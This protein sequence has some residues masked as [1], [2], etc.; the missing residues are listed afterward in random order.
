MYKYVHKHPPKKTQ[1]NVKAGWER[2]MSQFMP[3]LAFAYKHITLPFSFCRRTAIIWRLS[4]W[5]GKGTG[6]SLLRTASFW[7]VPLFLAREGLVFTALAL[8]LGFYLVLI[9]WLS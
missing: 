9:L 5:A 6:T 8:D 3:I 4:R 1:I 7:S 2:V